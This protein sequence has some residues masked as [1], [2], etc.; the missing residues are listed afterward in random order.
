MANWLITSFHHQFVAH[1]RQSSERC[2]LLTEGLI[3]KNSAKEMA[4]KNPPI[5]SQKLTL[6]IEPRNTSLPSVVINGELAVDEGG[7]EIL[8]P[9]IVSFNMSE[10]Q[11]RKLAM[12]VVLDGLPQYGHLEVRDRT[13]Q[14][15]NSI[16]RL[17]DGSK[18]CK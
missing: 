3:K 6:T 2:L 11:I 18:K 1:Q 5:A 14:T 8:S 13:G 17:M 9:D 4:V 12:K 15:R 16:V 10:E 7:V